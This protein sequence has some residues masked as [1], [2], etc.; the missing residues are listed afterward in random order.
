VG[1]HNVYSLRHSF[2]MRLLSRGVGIKAIGDVLG[3][4]DLQSTRSYLRLD[5]H[6]LRDVALP[7]PRRRSDGGACHA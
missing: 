7:V 2:A 4:R 5:V 3:H 6:S 1:S